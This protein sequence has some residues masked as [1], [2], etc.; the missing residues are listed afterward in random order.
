MLLLCEKDHAG[1]ADHF[2]ISKQALSN[3]FYRGS[4][5]AQEL[6]EAAEYCECEIVINTPSGNSIK[7]ESCDSEKE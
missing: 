2:G 1:L 3:K 6:I 7:F 4:F 5:T